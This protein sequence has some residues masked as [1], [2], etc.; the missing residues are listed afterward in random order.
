MSALR[1]VVSVTWVVGPPLAGLLLTS[2]LGEP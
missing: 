2:M 1:S